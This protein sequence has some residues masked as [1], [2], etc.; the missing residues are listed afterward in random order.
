MSARD[1][2]DLIRTADEFYERTNSPN[3]VGAADG[4]HVRMRKSKE[5][6]SQF[7][8]YK[9]FF[10]AVF[11]AVADA[12][13]CFISLEFGAYGSSN[14]SNVFKN[15][16]FGKLLECNK[17][18][19]SDPRSMPSDAEELST[20]FVLVGDEAFALSEHVLQPYPNKTLTYLKRICNYR[21]SRVRRVPECTVGILVNRWRV[22]YRPIYVKPDFCGNIMKACCVLHNYVWKYDG[23]HFDDTLYECPLESVQPVGTRGSDRGIA[24]RKYFAKNFTSP[25]KP[26]SWQYGNM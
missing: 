19:I 11:M 18:N 7:F 16:T 8:N 3:C 5:S 12:G 6:G 22:F 24:V 10:S 25:Q 4:K 23:I 1:K 2:N 14:N 17:L 26:V 13:Y 21:L 15:M 20:T 9:H